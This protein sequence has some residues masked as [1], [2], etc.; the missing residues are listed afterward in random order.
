MNYWK[1]DT[2]QAVAYSSDQWYKATATF[3][4]APTNLTLLYLPRIYYHDLVFIQSL[5]NMK[6]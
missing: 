3:F 5:E 2:K 1:L 4:F 6:T